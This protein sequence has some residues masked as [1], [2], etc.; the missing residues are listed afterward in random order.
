MAQL[1]TGKLDLKLKPLN[2][3]LFIQQIVDN[4]QIIYDKKHII[5]FKN[6]ETAAQPI[7]SRLLHQIADN[8]ISNA[9]KYSLPG[10]EVRVLV[11]NYT[12]QCRLTVQDQG[13]GI[14]AA[15]QIQLFDA[16]QRGSNVGNVPG[17]GLGLALVKQ[18]VALLG[19]SIHC[20]SQVGMGTTMTVM[21]PPQQSMHESSAHEHAGEVAPS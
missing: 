12:G 2:V 13:I 4:F 21:L 6:Q 20:E 15:D 17:T 7:D 11:D 14:P 16:F 18:A 10:G 3:G 8:L 1:E 19:G 9:I 5:W